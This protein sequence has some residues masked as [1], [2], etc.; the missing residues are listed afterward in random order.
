MIDSIKNYLGD[1]A[2][3]IG[4]GSGIVSEFLLRYFRNV[5]ATDIDFKSLLYC[6]TNTNSKIT[7]ICCDA[8]IAISGKFD[9][10]VSNPP[11]LP[12][13]PFYDGT[14]HGGI[15]GIEKTI[16]FIESGIKN[17]KKNGYI[18]LIVSSLS[19]TWK[20]DKFICKKKLNKKIINKKKLFSETLYVYELSLI[21]E[22]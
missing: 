3:E 4:T 21:N 1:S 20:M 11:Y 9:L 18:I 22:K 14:I 10:I 7:L 15:T 2:L 5:V 6:K 16:H 17:L 12:N 19:D 8:T 13:D